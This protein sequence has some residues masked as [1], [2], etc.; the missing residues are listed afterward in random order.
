MHELWVRHW[1]QHSGACLLLGN[2]LDGLVGSQGGP[3]GVHLGIAVGVGDR[4]VRGGD[5]PRGACREGRGASGGSG[6][7]SQQLR[8]AAPACMVLQLLE[9]MLST[10]SWAEEGAGKNGLAG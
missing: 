1:A 5:L 6:T 2:L 3:G 10:V 9:V 7:A 8:S 4:G